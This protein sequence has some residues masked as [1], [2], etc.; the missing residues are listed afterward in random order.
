MP[1]RD[2]W[3]TETGDRAREHA[4]RF[5][6]AV[7][8]A[9]RFLVQAGA[10]EDRDTALD[11]FGELLALDVQP[12]RCRF[13]SACLLLYSDFPPEL[14]SAQDD[15]RSAACVSDAVE[16]MPDVATARRA[17]DLLDA[18]TAPEL[19]AETTTLR[20]LALSVTAVPDGST[21]EP[22]DLATMIAVLGQMLD[23]VR[24]EGWEETPLLEALHSALRS[25]QLGTGGSDPGALLKGVAAAVDQLPADHPL[26]PALLDGLADI[27]NPDVHSSKQ[28]V[29]AQAARLERAFWA[30]AAG[31]ADRP[32]LA[33]RAVST[34]VR[35]HA[36]GVESE[37]R[38]RGHTILDEMARTD[39]RTYPVLDML[40]SALIAC[41]TMMGGEGG[42]VSASVSGLLR[43]G[44][45]LAGTN[46]RL[47]ELAV[48]MAAAVLMQRYSRTG[49]RDDLEA[50]QR[51]VDKVAGGS[52]DEPTAGQ[53]YM[54]HLSALALL[55]PSDDPDHQAEI[56]ELVAGLR[57]LPKPARADLFELSNAADLA[58]LSG[59]AETLAAADSPQAVV[60]AARGV[61]DRL[62]D[63]LD[64]VLA[65]PQD[66]AIYPLTLAELAG[67]YVIYG[68]LTNQPDALDRGL[69]LFAD[70]R[71]CAEEQSAGELSH[72][73]GQIGQL[74]GMCL[75]V[76]AGRTRRPADLG[77]AIGVLAESLGVLEGT[78]EDVGRMKVL[79]MLGEAHYLR[80][81]RDRG[82][83]D[84]AVQAGLEYLREGAW[85]VV[86]QNSLAAAA[87]VAGLMG[88][89]AVQVARWALA[90][91]LD[92]TAVEALELGRS[93]VLYSATADR[94]L[95]AL[96]AEHGHAE[97]AD[98]WQRGL[99]GADP[100]VL[101]RPDGLRTEVSA[102]LTRYGIPG[103]LRD[104]VRHA[105]RDIGVQDRL[106]S[107]TGPAEVGRA[108]AA[109]GSDALVY[110]ISRTAPG[111]LVRTPTDGRGLALIV[112]ADGRT[113][114]LELPL[115]DAAA[116]TGP[117][118][119][120][121]AAQRARVA[122]GRASA[123]RDEADEER[124]SWCAALDALCRWAWTVAM[125]P[126][127]NWATGHGLFGGRLVLVPLEDLS[128]VPWHAAL[129]EVAGGG[130]RAACQDAVIGYAASGRQF[131]EAARH[132]PR[133]WH[134]SVAL[135]N[136]AD[137]GLYWATEEIKSLHRREYPDAKVLGDGRRRT[138]RADADS[139]VALIPDAS[140]VHLSCH[141][142]P[143]SRPVDSELLLVGGERLA[144]AD[145]L[146]RARDRAPGVP[147][148]L[149][150]AAACGTDLSAAA[151]DESLTLTSAF[152][153]AGACGAIGSRWIVDDLPAAV[154]MALFHHYLNS[155]Y[156][157]PPRALQAAQC[158]ML[159]PEADPPEAVAELFGDEL[160]QV[161]LSAP[162]AWAAFVYQGR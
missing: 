47:R 9:Q 53:Q 7:R 143:A 162:E 36:Y 89:E 6:H 77:T 103:D 111:S 108:L 160:T 131:V 140:L 28:E 154:F 58:S 52:A 15:L 126:L 14:R 107:R 73:V 11:A 51:L 95:S 81:D 31:H 101:G 106:W 135:V 10:R 61:L 23:D 39:D 42:D 62:D 4:I 2:P 157:D 99:A 151:H 156:P 50:V 128:Q 17:L 25:A 85:Q 113:H 130:L 134:E 69:R 41:E 100:H 26:R 55:L 145:I 80:G 45:S 124:T 37:G 70:A 60:A 22:D 44:E 83:V 88:G 139:V 117:V 46:E 16:G 13:A 115:L 48:D 32:R 63:V 18:I 90:G 97:L 118:A 120:W 57:D 142:S 144:M 68:D 102:V 78:G 49:R 146:R 129:R 38:R 136:V 40:R 109:T 141:A 87:A 132:E 27:L 19:A 148:G 92:D 152:L 96:L 122:R 138:A 5:E 158:W 127:L 30:L 133:P 71:E 67:Q 35:L 29:E 137:S 24:E 112:D 54:T 74:F 123:G 76:K 114:R 12:D 147:G 91:G 3:D 21:P 59:F 1:D 121:A 43:H 161:A 93:M 110:L 104:R 79:R 159:D 150:L 149:V 125:G 98:E 64:S 119:T 84:Q 20:A 105:V 82:D 75:L 66:V 65:I 116:A 86:L 56:A 34:L 94:N 153:A 72:V 155:G 8:H 33:S